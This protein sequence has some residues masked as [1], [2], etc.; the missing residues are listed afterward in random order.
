MVTPA[1]TKLATREER[2][3]QL[4]NTSGAVQE[5][6]DGR[7]YVE[8]LAHVGEGHLVDAEHGTCTCQDF[9]KRG[10]FCKHLLAVAEHAYRQGGRF[11]VAVDESGRVARWRR[12]PAVETPEQKRARV[13]AAVDELFGPRL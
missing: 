13:Y 12:L 9:A 7:F 1:T 6:P 11:S 3:L 8:S 4:A 5:R 10:S 2:A